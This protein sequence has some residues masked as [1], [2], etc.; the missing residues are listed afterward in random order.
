M[1]TEMTSISQCWSTS[2]TKNNVVS[3][4]TLTQHSCLDSYG[5]CSVSRELKTGQALN[6]QCKKPQ[7]ISEVQVFMKMKQN[8]KKCQSLVK[9]HNMLQQL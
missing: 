4:I 8:I 2:F 9:Q 7:E 3:N 1:I 5:K 6:T